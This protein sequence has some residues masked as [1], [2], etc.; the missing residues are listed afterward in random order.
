MNVRISHP[1]VENEITVAESAVPFHAA[2]GW[3]VIEDKPADEKPAEGD[4]KPQ[5]ER[6]RASTT[7]K[8]EG[9]G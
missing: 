8:K 9:Q 6:P 4:G 7:K 5:G 3:S 2:S 1:E